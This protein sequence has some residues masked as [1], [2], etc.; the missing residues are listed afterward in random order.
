KDK[1]TYIPMDTFPI[2][3]DKVPS[4]KKGWLLF[5][6]EANGASHS[7]QMASYKLIL[8]RE[9][10]NHKLHDKCFIIAAGNLDT[11]NAITNTMSSA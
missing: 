11:D 5:L 4:N 7:V 6:D 9:V 3:S 10:G 2:Q 8:D 1:V